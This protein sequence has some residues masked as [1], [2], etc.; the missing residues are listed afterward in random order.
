[1]FASIPWV[2]Q[3][4]HPGKLQ[5]HQTNDTAGTTYCSGFAIGVCG[6][7]ANH[8]E[9][10]CT[11]CHKFDVGVAVLHFPMLRQLCLMCSHKLFQPLQLQIA[12][13]LF[14]LLLMLPSASTCTTCCG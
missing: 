3:L 11:R 5:T 9:I 4:L 6:D 2:Y 10:Q 1:M 8:R 13:L 12:L 7:R 14:L